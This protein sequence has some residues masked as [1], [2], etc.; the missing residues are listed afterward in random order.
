LARKGNK[1]ASIRLEITRLASQG[2]GIAET[3]N[4][5]VYVPFTA[6]GDVVEARP[7]KGPRGA[8]RAKLVRLIAPS[9]Q[10]AEPVCRHFGVC[11]ACALQHIPSQAYA[12]WIARRIRTALGHHG[13]GETAI[14]EPAISPP[15]SR[16][17]LALKALR[18]G[19][20]VVLGFHERL[21]H[22]LVDIA[23]CPVA[24]PGLVAC[25]EPLRAALSTCLAA[26]QAATVTL[27][28]TATGLDVLI[29]G[30]GPLTLQAREALAALAENQD[31][32]AL[33][34]YEDG[35]LDPIAVR[36][37]PEMRFD[38][39]S[40]AFPP[41][42]FVQATAEGEAVLRRAVGDW[43]GAARSVADLFCGLGTFSLALARPARVTAVEGEA[44]LAESLAAAGRRHG[45][46]GLTAQH[47]DL[48]RD[49]LTPAELEPFEAVVFDPPRAGAKSQ[50]GAIAA[51][52]VA[53]VVGISCNPNTFA[54]D[55][56][57]L[58]DGGYDLVELRP[59]DQFLWS[60]QLE[61][62]ALFIRRR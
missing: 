22:K 40:V 2:D 60:G 30:P 25:F 46:D 10:R 43:T 26:N 16:R 11:G 20:G 57:I 8:R 51:S 3:E 12:D 7:Q 15:G 59:V 61:L 4:G 1:P 24:R 58:V 5:P 62:A 52:N 28:E 19:K 55:A 33:H 44:V 49:P 36:R 9:P 48:F 29:A 37:A 35:F 39:L 42:A 53:T 50:A 34:F 21:S 17:R 14:A 31:L 45:L 56:R 13:L 38:E 27:T 41:G 32:A 23:E 18:T 47:R 54:R 6:P